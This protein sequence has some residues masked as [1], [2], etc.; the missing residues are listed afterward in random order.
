MRSAITEGSGALRLPR[1]AWVSPLPVCLVVKFIPWLCGENAIG[2]RKNRKPLTSIRCGVRSGQAG[3]RDGGDWRGRACDRLRPGAFRLR[4]AG[5]SRPARRRRDT[6]VGGLAATCNTPDYMDEFLVFLGASCFRAIPA[7]APYGL[8]ARSRGCARTRM[9][10]TC[11]ARCCSTPDAA[12]RCARQWCGRG[13]P[14]S[15][16][17]PTWPCS[18]GCASARIGSRVCASGSSAESGLGAGT[19]AGQGNLRLITYID[20]VTETQYVLEEE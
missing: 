17:S 6:R 8:S 11:C 3:Q 19:T 20:P 10:A 4:Q 16:I 1:P 12:I 13:G 18:S 14:A 9:R 5:L 2:Q 15:R 7:H